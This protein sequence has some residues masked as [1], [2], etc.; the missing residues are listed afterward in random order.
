MIIQWLK[1]SELLLIISILIRAN[2]FADNSRTILDDFF[3]YDQNNLIVCN[4]SKITIFTKN[5]EEIVFF[6]FL[7]GAD[8]FA[9][10]S[11]QFCS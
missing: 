3:T 7:I 4:D 8:N 6:L 10:N 11:G 5:K 2:N 9:D 1:N